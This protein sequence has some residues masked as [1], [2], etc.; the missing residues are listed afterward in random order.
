MSTR[1]CVIANALGP[2]GATAPPHDRFLL[3]QVA[4][5]TD[6]DL[7]GLPEEGLPFVGASIKSRKAYSL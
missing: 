6:A 2:W 1:V 4:V 7:E 5:R 3:P